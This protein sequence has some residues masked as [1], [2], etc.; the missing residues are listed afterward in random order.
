MMTT[1]TQE[2]VLGEGILQWFHDERMSDRYGLV[3]LH[4]EA[5][6]PYWL[7]IGVRAG[8]DGTLIAEVAETRASEH[9][10]DLFHGVFPRQTPVGE[11]RI[12]GSGK[13]LSVER[14][15]HH[16]VGVLPSDGRDEQWMDMRALYDVHSHVVKLIWQ[17]Q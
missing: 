11:R 12:L 3:Y 8:E 13:L 1:Q 7:N 10:G 14:E 5:G 9:V 17:P 4:T 6:A 16:Q 2:I 15:D